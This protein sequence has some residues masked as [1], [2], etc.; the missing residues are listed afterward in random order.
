MQTF[1]CFIQIVS[2]RKWPK[3]LVISPQQSFNES[4][5]FIILYEPP[6]SWHYLMLTLIVT[7]VIVS[8]FFPY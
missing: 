8:F 6:T 7:G 4:S 2:L 5:F 3:R 1:H